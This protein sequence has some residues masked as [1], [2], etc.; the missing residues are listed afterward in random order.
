MQDHLKPYFKDDEAGVGF[1]RCKRQRTGRQMAAT[2]PVDYSLG[3]P[4]VVVMHTNVVET[5]GMVSAAPTTMVEQAIAVLNEVVIRGTHTQRI[6]LKSQLNSMVRLLEEVEEFELKVSMVALSSSLPDVG[7][8]LSLNGDDRSSCDDTSRAPCK[9][10]LEQEFAW[11]LSQDDNGPSSSQETFQ[12][13]GSPSNFP[14]E[15]LDE[16]YDKRLQAMYED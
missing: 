8:P 14:S 16:Q 15:S 13:D 4:E 12:V 11:R 3:I 2:D 1:K 6:D 7:F 10:Q 9:S 5:S